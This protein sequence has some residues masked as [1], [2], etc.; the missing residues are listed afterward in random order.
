MRLIL[1]FICISL[2]IAHDDSHNHDY[3]HSHGHHHSPIGIIRGSV[4]DGML[5]EIK[6][7][8]N[9]SIVK[10]GT[11]DIIAGGISDENGMFLIDQIPF[12]KYYLVI[13]IKK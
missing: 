6:M 2:I 11:E 9:I 3:G 4:I 8:A 1:L 13:G 10:D 12:G 5:D 7:Y